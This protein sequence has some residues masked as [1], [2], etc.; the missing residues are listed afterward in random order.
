MTTTRSQRQERRAAKDMDLDLTAGSGSK[1]VKNDGRARRDGRAYPESAEF[2]TTGN[3]Y[4]RLHLDDLVK[5]A[6]QA[7]QDQ[8]MSLFGIEFG[9]ARGGSSWRYV[10][11][12]EN[13]YLELINRVRVLEEYLNARDDSAAAVQAKLDAELG[14]L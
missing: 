8:R 12:E 14:D 9:N 2:K 11:L 13:D 1:T 3:I 5:A 10:V 7:S 6:R 4:Y